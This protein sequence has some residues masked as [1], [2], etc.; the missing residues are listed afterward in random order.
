MF[1][2]KKRKIIYIE[3]MSCEHCVKKVE[4]ALKNLVDITKVKVQLKKKA[5]II[6]YENEVDDLLLQKVIED[7]GYTVIGIK[8]LV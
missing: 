7:L 2:Q 1:F 6:S 3:G 5:A 4:T 8:D